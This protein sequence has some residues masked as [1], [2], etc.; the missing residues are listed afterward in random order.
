MLQIR[1]CFGFDLGDLFCCFLFVV[2]FV[3][4][5]FLLVWV[6]VLP[7]TDLG[8]VA[9]IPLLLLELLDLL[10]Y[11]VYF[12]CIVVSP[13]PTPFLPFLFSLFNLLKAD[14]NPSPPITP[15]PANPMPK[16]ITLPKIKKHNKVQLDIDAPGQQIGG[17]NYFRAVDAVHHAETG[18]LG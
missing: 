6:E 16:R 12:F 17:Q 10:Q 1:F 7:F 3:V 4:V 11:G 18:C 15:R 2:I 14:N 13:Y 5:L 9:A 8:H